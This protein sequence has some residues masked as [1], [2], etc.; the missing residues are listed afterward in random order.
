MKTCNKKILFLFTVNYPFSHG[1]H[2]LQYETEALL[3][4]FDKVVIV[5]ADTKSQQ[6]YKVDKRIDIVRNS[7]GLTLANKGFS[8]LNIFSNYFWYEI[9]I[10]LFKYKERVSISKIYSILL[11]IKKGKKSEK[12]INEEL[13]K[14]TKY[15]I[16][17]YSW[18][19]LTITN[20]F[21]F[22][23]KK[24]PEITAMTRARAID[25]YFERHKT[26][27]IPLRKYLYETLDSIF[28]ISKDGQNYISNK[29][30]SER[31]NN[32]V[33]VS[34]VGC[35]NRNKYIN[36]IENN[37]PQKIVTC[38]NIIP[39]KRL[40][41]LIEALA[42]FKNEKIHWIHFG[43]GDLRDEIEDLS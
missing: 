33:K 35:I 6:L 3:K 20:G 24:H 1:E 34:R 12:F 37:I 36:T 42:F 22:I 15:D 14:Y 19:T 40:H 13:K 25:L 4:E 5:C 8:L 30:N 2:L 16:Y 10:I 21:A 29:F 32:R 31:I 18:W 28:C 41:L 39:L 17:L 7:F 26:D 38:S 9:C 43:E 11:A 23:K 27:Y